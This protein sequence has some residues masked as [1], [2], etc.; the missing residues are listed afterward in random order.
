PAFGCGIGDLADL[1]VL[2]RDRSGVDDAAPLIVL[3]RIETDHPRR[4][5]SDAAKGAD[6]IDG[7]RQFELLHRVEFDFAGRLVAANRLGGIG[8]AGAIDQ[9]ALLA[10]RLAGPR[11]SR[12]DFFVA[13]HVDLAE[14][15][16]DFRGDLA[17]LVRVAIEHRD[18][19]SA[20]RKLPRRRLAEPRRASGNNRDSALYVHAGAFAAMLDLA[21]S[22]CRPMRWNR[23]ITKRLIP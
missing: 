12:G 17:A 1:P 21:S 23:A 13:G 7:D 16:A 8:D 20:P 22:R 5:K 6:Q 3:E 19:G 15:A 10:M 9:H 11:K 18:L 2:R 14:N 4:R